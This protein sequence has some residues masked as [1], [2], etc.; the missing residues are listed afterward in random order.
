MKA[1]IDYLIGYVECDPKRHAEAYHPEALK[2]AF[3]FEHEGV[4]ALDY[5]TPRLMV[6]TAAAGISKV[7]GVE[8]EIF[9]DDVTD[10]MA[11]VRLYSTKWI[12][13]LHIVKA[14]GAWRILHATWKDQPQ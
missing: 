12:D 11:S 2:R 9:I 13:F 4:E 5:V 7:E 14:R 1:T 6:D 8:Y 10:V 3:Y